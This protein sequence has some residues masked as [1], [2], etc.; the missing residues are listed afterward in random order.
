MSIKQISKA[1]TSDAAAA[2]AGLVGTT[3]LLAQAHKINKLKKENANLKKNK[4]SK[5]AEHIMTKIAKKDDR[6]EAGYFATNMAA[7]RAMRR[8]HTG[9][10]QAVETNE[11]IGARFTQGLKHM[12]P[13]LGIGAGV[14]ATGGLVA[15][16]LSKGKY[17]PTKAQGAGMG[18]IA[19]G[20]LGA[21]TGDGIGQYKADKK[22]L[23]DRGFGLR[24]FGFRSSTLTPEAKKKYLSSKYQGGGFDVKNKPA[25]KAN[26]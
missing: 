18:A 5:K 8:G 23:A 22:Y 1:L 19:G 14:G 13:G 10:R 26:R 15:T 20:A 21:I 9:A 6:P 16:V 3:G 17:K 12:V 25:G 4:M 24:A 11:L 2:G 7:T